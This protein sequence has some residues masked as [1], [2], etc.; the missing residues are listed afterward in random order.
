MSVLKFDYSMSGFSPEY[1]SRFASTAASAD[2]ELANGTFN[3]TDWLDYPVKIE[4][5]KWEIGNNYSGIMNKY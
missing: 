3:N 5:R 4:E 1:L 2:K